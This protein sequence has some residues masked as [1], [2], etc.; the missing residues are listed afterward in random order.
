M[1]TASSGRDFSETDSC[2]DETDLSEDDIELPEM[3]DEELAI[4]DIQPCGHASIVLYL[5]LCANVLL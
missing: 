5:S 3:P 4:H 1:D 2:E